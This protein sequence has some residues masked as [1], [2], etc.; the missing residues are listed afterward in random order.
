MEVEVI[1]II[2][3][4]LPTLCFEC[5]FAARVNKMSVCAPKY[6]TRKQNNNHKYNIDATDY[7]PDWCPLITQEE[8][9]KQ[10]ASPF[11]DWDESE[12]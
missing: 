12:E 5:P 10:V 2:V 11:S 6:N 1:K 4:K 8:L 7:P 3:N 9:L